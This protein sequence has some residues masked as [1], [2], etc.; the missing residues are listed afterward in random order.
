[1]S[2]NSSG[3]GEQGSSF[4][5]EIRGGGGAGGA[6]PV[7]VPRKGGRVTSGMILVAGLIALSGGVLYG[8]R[9]YGRNLGMKLDK[10]DAAITETKK[11]PKTDAETA[12]I[13]AELE[14][15]G[16]PVQVPA[17]QI[18]RDPFVLVG[19]ASAVPD[20][21]TPVVE[22]A[23][24]DPMAALEQEIRGR[25][26]QLE[27]TSVMMGSSPVARI[28]GRIYRVNDS[29]ARTFTVMEISDRQVTLG[30]G[31]KSFVLRMK[32]DQAATEDDELSPV[33]GPRR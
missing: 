10:F 23:K 7:P 31:G 11:D 13:M 20:V 12:R 33:R 32:S 1:M 30:W 17:D 5:S 29:I 14:R 21:R 18:R 19:L 16:T 9:V 6:D 28:N 8:M 22:A 15:H 27:L 4:L 3:T 26:E 25:F 2:T 24:P